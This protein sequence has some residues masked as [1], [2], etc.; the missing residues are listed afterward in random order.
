MQVPVRTQDLSAASRIFAYVFP[1][2]QAA[3]DLDVTDEGRVLPVG[4]ISDSLEMVPFGTSRIVYLHSCRTILGAA[5]TAGVEPPVGDLRA[6]LQAEARGTSTT[7]VGLAHGTN[8]SALADAFERAEA[9]DYWRLAAH[10]YAWLWWRE[11]EDDRDSTQ[12]YIQSFQGASVYQASTTDQ[13]ASAGV[14]VSGG[15]A[16]PGIASIRGSL[17]AEYDRDDRTD[18]KRMGTIHWLGAQGRPKMTVRS[19]PTPVQIQRFVGSNVVL[20][21]VGELP[22]EITDANIYSYSAQVRGIP[23]RLCTDGAWTVEKAPESQLVFHKPGIAHADGICTFTISFSPTRPVPQNGVRLA[24]TLQATED[25]DG[26]RLRIPGHDFVLGTLGSPVLLPQAFERYWKDTSGVLSWDVPFQVQDPKNLLAWN[27][28]VLIVSPELRCGDAIIP[29]S[30]GNVAAKDQPNSRVLIPIRRQHFASDRLAVNDSTRWRTC[31][32]RALLRFGNR[33]LGT[34]PV[35][36]WY[37]YT[38]SPAPPSHPGLYTRTPD[39]RPGFYVSSGSP[40]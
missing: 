22:R 26:V 11:N 27:Q 2:E 32:Y 23:P 31:E 34:G 33:D 16:V 17:D 4:A 38:G 1:S 36:I 40:Q 37:P 12:Y 3:Y 13:S 8:Q 18:V 39:S 10:L 35:E 15:A 25:I 29:L 9:P 14:T 6:A 28:D 24:Y 19:L 30:G 7:R 20:V 5:V 21:P